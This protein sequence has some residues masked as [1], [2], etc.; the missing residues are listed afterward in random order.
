MAQWLGAHAA[1]AEDPGSVSSTHTGLSLTPDPGAQTA[2]FG[3]FRS[4]YAFDAHT[5]V[6]AETQFLKTFKKFIRNVS[7]IVKKY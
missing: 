4:R 5:Y 2:F 1:L 6:Q 7:F 3:L